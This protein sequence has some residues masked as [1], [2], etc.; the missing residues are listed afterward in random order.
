MNTEITSKQ[1][2]DFLGS[3]AKHYDQYMGP[4]FFEPYAIEVS[5]LVDA[6]SVQVALELAAGTGRVTRHLRSVLAPTAKL[7][8]SDISPDMLAVGKEKLKDANIEWQI[9]DAQDL[10]FA[11][12]SIDL[13]VCC[14]GL[15][16]MPDK[17]KVCSEVYRVLRAG[18]MFIVT[19]WDK[20]EK[21]GTSFVYRS[22]AEKYLSQ[23]LPESY[24][25]PT[26]MHDESVVR[27]LLLGAGFSRVAVAKQEKDSQCRSAKDAAEALTKGGAL[28]NEIMSR[29]PSWV[30][31]IK[32][33]VE[34]ELASRYGDAPMTA[35]ISAL[36]GQAWK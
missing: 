23:P 30:D 34:K 6:S 19:T 24:N 8:A 3:A 35:P 13:V 25:L 29:D 14:F 11:N 17:L 16:F 33:L 27:E 10:P 36:I 21:N 28:S 26:S 1:P 12:G 4:M 32:F 2:F 20:L 31:E 9:I 5:K 18:G 7:I 22:I 15:M